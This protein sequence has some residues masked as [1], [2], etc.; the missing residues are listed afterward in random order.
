MTRSKRGLLLLALGGALFGAGCEEKKQSAETA[1]PDA[2]AA[3]DKYAT[4]D[5]KLAK[6]LQATTSTS[7]DSDKG[8]PP[9]GVFPPGGADR[10]HPKGTPTKVDFVSDGSEPRVSLVAP[11]DGVSDPARTSYGPASLEL[12]MQMGPR[13]ALPT[14]DLALALAPAK[15]D[16]GGSDWLLADVKKAIPAR[17]QLGQ[18]PPGAEKEI[19]SLEG[20]SIHIKTTP[21]GRE[22]DLQVRLS[23]KA[24]ADLERIAMS[25]AEAL[26]FSAVPIPAKPVGVGA[27]WIAETRMPLSG[28]DV[29]AYRAY[30][31]KDIDGDRLHL[32]LDVK[33]YAVDKEAQLQGVPKGAT[34]EQFESQSGGELELV[35]GESLARKSN[36]QQRLVMVFQAPGGAAAPSAPGQPPGNMLTAQMQSRATLVRGDDLRV[37]A[38]QP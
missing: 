21:D 7:A 29:I 12:E 19:G 20:T 38:K 9:E 26:V 31:V 16:E 32:A 8:P 17:Q 18:L 3:T 13:V 30:R 5:P 25:A 22:S 35:R 15:K 33:A 36:V 27:L 4:A 10:R 37:T 28:L 34:L 23:K 6:A 2:N 14:I 11:S 24:P 1:L